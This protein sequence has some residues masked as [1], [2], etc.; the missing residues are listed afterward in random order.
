MA[1][2]A[3]RPKVLLLE[4]PDPRRSPPVTGYPDQI[5][6]AREARRCWPTPAGGPTATTWDEIAELSEARSVA[7]RAVRV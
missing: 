1:G 7:G 5:E 2:P 3:E 6:L 4:W